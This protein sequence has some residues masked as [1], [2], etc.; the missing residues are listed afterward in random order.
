MLNLRVRLRH[1]WFGNHPLY[2]IMH[3]TLENVEIEDDIKVQKLQVPQLSFQFSIMRSTSYICVENWI[4]LVDTNYK[5]GTIIW[6]QPDKYTQTNLKSEISW[7][8]FKMR[9]FV[10]GSIGD[11]TSVVFSSVI[12]F[13]SLTCYSSTSFL[14]R[15]KLKQ[16]FP[17]WKLYSPP[18]NCFKIKMLRGMNNVIYNEN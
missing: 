9:L 17:F 5:R 14:N 16:Y 2:E 8:S 18:V 4:L 12:Y 10:G 6:K 3:Q 11:S 7:Y 1:H 15:M 13:D